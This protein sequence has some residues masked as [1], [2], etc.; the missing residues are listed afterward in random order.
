MVAM[1]LRAWIGKLRRKW[2]RASDAEDLYSRITGKEVLHHDVRRSLLNA[3]KRQP[4]LS[5]P[6][7]K[8]QCGLAAGTVEWHL[9]KLED[10]GFI[11]ASKDGRT[12]RYFPSDTPPDMKEAMVQLQNASRRELVSRVLRAPA[13][14]PQGEL[15]TRM[16]LSHATVHHHAKRLMEADLL[17][18]EK[19][20]R[21][22]G[23]R[24]PDDN[25]TT[26][27]KALQKIPP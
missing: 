14:V 13:E 27:E 1:G 21:T 26:V 12:R 4:G 5:F 9:D 19:D 20:G 6:E 18:K 15:A 8:R 25:R 17:E 10:E 22:V 23:Y 7:L 16:G 24:V 3:L 2:A 11:T